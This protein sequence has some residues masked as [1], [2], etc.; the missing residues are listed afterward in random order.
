M[1]LIIVLV[2]LAI[3]FDYLN[4][5]HDSSN[6]VATII[7]SRALSPAW[8]LALSAAGNFAG[9]FIFGVAVAKTIGEGIV[10]PTHISMPVILATLVSSIFWNLITWFFGIPSS[11]SHALIGGLIGAVA[12]SVGF[13]AIHPEGLIKVAIAL[14]GSP[15]IGL[16][17]GFLLTKLIFL[18]SR[19]AHPRINGF[20]RGA[21]VLTGIALSLSHGTNDAQKT[22]GIITMGL[23]SGGLLNTFEVPFW[24][25]AASAGAIALGTATGGWRL[26]RTLGGKFYKIRPVHGFS[27]QFTAAGVILG[28]A[29]LGGPVSTTQV[30]GSAIAGVGA[31][32]RVNKVRWGVLGNIALAWVFTIPATAGVSAL[33]YLLIKLFVP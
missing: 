13:E 8:A 3:V 16:V 22:M 25:V 21:Q 27:T 30:V 4:G 9:P 10:D 5:F 33:L 23:V 1:T 19:N 26:I 6:V 17:V 7:S 12:V 11:S 31:A 29:L 20:F 15:V 24:V 32:E 14:F 28:A 18:L 2:I